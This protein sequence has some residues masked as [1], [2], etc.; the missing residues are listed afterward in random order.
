[1]VHR[2]ALLLTLASALHAQPEF[3]VASVKA[4]DLST[5][6]RPYSMSFGANHNEVVFANARLLEIIRWAY[7]ITSDAQVLGPDWLFS[8]Q[9]LYDILAKAA[10]GAPSEQLPVML[11]ALLGDRFKLTVHREPKEM[12]YFRLITAKN[13]PKMKPAA[14]FPAGYAQTVTSGHIDTVL[15]MT[16]LSIL[17][18]RF[19]IPDPIVDATGLTGMFYVNLE[20]AHDNPRRPT[21]SPGPSLY[22]ALQEQLG[23]KLEPFKGPIPVLV[24]DHVEQ[25]SPN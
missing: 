13:G 4:V 25:P 12:S 1:M 18:A 20:W 6:G 22:T 19:E 24:I 2:V 7:G 17:L 5:L 3:D 16:T 15:D 23:L 8:K 21:D 10:P 11:Q 9:R 14:E